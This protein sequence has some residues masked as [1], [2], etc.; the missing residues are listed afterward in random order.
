[1]S[2]YHLLRS[3]RW[4]M[5]GYPAGT[6]KAFLARSQYW[7]R[8][9]L[10]AYR[11]EQ[12][13][14]LV[15]HCYQNVPYY[16]RT[17]EQAGVR[18]AD[19]RCAEDL[20]KLPLLTKRD[21]RVYSKDL[22]ARNVADTAVT[23]IRTG[24]TTGE[25][26]RIAKDV[27]CAAWEGMC[28]ERGLEWGGL[29]ADQ[30]RVRLFGGSLGLDRSSWTARLG[31]FLRRDLF[32]PAFELRRDTASLYFERIR[33]SRSRHLIG[34][35]SAIFRLA[36]LSE[37]MNASLRFD[38]VFPT[39]EQLLPE[40]EAAIRRIFKSE[41]LPYYGC[42]E[43]NSLGYSVVGSRSYVIPEEQCLIEVLQ[44]DRT[45][46]MDR[47]TRCDGEG[48][49][50]ITSLVNY[51][52]PLLRYVNGD[53]G[54][55]EVPGI[56][57]SSPFARIQRL[58]GRYNSLL[59][60]ERGDLISG[61]IGPHVFRHVV[62]AVQSYRIIQEEP[63]RLVIQ[64]VPMEAGLSSEQEALIRRLFAEHLGERMKIA[65][66]RVEHLPALPSGKSMSVVNRCL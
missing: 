16:R 37:E 29:S 24:G 58:D 65:I 44:K 40:W 63:L 43:V 30:P 48:R 52:M 54:A 13:Q 18:P 57:S 45:T 6:I 39:A 4:R 3:A 50:V 28:F 19:I 60:T 2:L 9:R 27:H 20:V 46:Q 59:M 15:A 51:A 1:M 8:P 35:A 36:V 25:P 5:Q 56:T 33:R 55:L 64:I 32:L 53:V 42:G 12:I 31:S 41:I 26:I 10:T 34:Y 21:I 66:E 61:A 7:D 17:M 22:R 38:V 62:G 49:F 14:R 47:T 23:W 11:D